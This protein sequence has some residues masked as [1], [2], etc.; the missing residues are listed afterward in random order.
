M[1]YFS[2]WGRFL[3]SQHLSKLWHLILCR[4]SWWLRWCSP[5]QSPGGSRRD[6]GHAIGAIAGATE[7][8]SRAGRAVVNLTPP[9]L[10]EITIAVRCRAALRRIA[11]LEFELDDRPL[12]RRRAIAF[13]PLH[14]QLGCTLDEHVSAHLERRNGR[15]VRACEVR[16]TNADNRSI[17][18]DAPP[19]RCDCV[20]H[21]KK[22]IRSLRN[23]RSRRGLALKKA[24]NLIEC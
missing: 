2:A 4:L 18:R 7:S 22:R 10:L 14:E 17:I 11:A 19:R 23:E 3:C 16:V 20:E 21:A 13:A 1:P 5:C 6:F 12:W 8:R 9:D 24:N 15:D